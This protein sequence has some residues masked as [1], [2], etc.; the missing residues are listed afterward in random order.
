VTPSMIQALQYSNYLAGA[1]DELILAPPLLKNPAAEHITAENQELAPLLRIVQDDFGA[2]AA[3]IVQVERASGQV[4]IILSS[5]PQRDIL[6]PGVLAGRPTARRHADESLLRWHE[7]PDSDYLLTGLYAEPDLELILVCCFPRVEENARSAIEDGIE[8][9]LTLMRECVRFWFSSVSNRRK[10]QHLASAIDLS[11]LGVFLIDR[12]GWIAY[13]N[14]EGEQLL[15][16]GDGLRRTGAAISALHMRD[17]IRLTLAIEEF[18]SGES[19]RA[20]AMLLSI[21]R[22]ND[23]PPLMV[24]VSGS[25]KD[26]QRVAL[27]HVLRPDSEIGRMIVPICKLYGLSPV[28]TQVVRC[29]VEGMTITE[30]A[31]IMRIKL[32]TARGYLKQIFDKIGTARQT[33]LVRMMMGSIICTRSDL[34]VEAVK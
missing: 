21:D 10:S 22:P 6:H 24:M 26:G 27:L 4:R 34:N 33:D 12:G 8:S 31:R 15:A 3:M 7:G 20:D 19:Q 9:S 5:T 25:E 28:E 2:V 13:A 32:H 16:Q 18:L 14:A 17:S 11:S 30:A 1:Q 29:L 23:R